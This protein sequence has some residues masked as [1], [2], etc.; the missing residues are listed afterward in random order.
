MA[1]SSVETSI[2]ETRSAL[3]CAQIA[4]GALYSAIRACLQV[5]VVPVF[6]KTRVGLACAS[7]CART[8]TLRAREAFFAARIKIEIRAAA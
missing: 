8:A 4:G 2:E 6:V 5:L 1:C 3:F 7:I